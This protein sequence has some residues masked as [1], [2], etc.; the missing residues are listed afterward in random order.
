MLCLWLNLLPHS[1]NKEKFISEFHKSFN[2]IKETEIEITKN[3]FNN[4]NAQ[5]HS[6]FSSERYSTGYSRC[7]CLL[8]SN[9]ISE[10][11]ERVKRCL[12]ET[13]NNSNEAVS[14]FIY[15]TVDKR[16]TDI[17]KEVIFNPNSLHFLNYGNPFRYNNARKLCEKFKHTLEKANEKID[18]YIIETSMV[19][20]IY[21]VRN[22]SDLDYSTLSENDVQF[23]EKQIERH[24]F[25]GQQF[26]DCPI[27]S[28][29][30]DSTN[31]FVYN[32]MKFVSLERLLQYKESRFKNGGNYKDK[33]DIILITKL[34]EGGRG[35]WYE[36][37]RL[38]LLTQNE[39]KKKVNKFKDQLKALLIRFR[40]CKNDSFRI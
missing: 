25:F 27:R 16:E 6:L 23:S 21:G 22:A 20:A 9:S 1:V 4:L 34:L 10:I 31:Y 15:I 12:R 38:R 26:Y 33:T 8:I 28:L 19:L 13:G 39:W 2:V 30:E 32:E 37:L 11:E 18:D 14:S 40:I 29:I 24:G 35:F 5:F 3:V 17:M 7:L 36:L